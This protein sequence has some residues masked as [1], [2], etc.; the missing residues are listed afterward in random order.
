[1]AV[2]PFAPYA[3]KPFEYQ[4]GNGFAVVAQHA[5][6]YLFRIVSKKGREPGFQVVSASGFKFVE[7]EGRPVGLPL[8]II[9]FVRIVKESPKPREGEIF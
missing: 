2:C 7:E 6:V 5:V 4:I 8:R 9:H 3:G 1:M